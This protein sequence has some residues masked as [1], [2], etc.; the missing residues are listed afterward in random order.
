[1][2]DD[3]IEADDI[4]DNEGKDGNFPVF[5][6]GGGGGVIVGGV[7]GGDDVGICKWVD[8]DVNG[9]NVCCCCC[10]WNCCGCSDDLTICGVL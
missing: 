10:C 1:M 8:N 5:I 9:T 6:D 7:S 4:D 2:I 3:D